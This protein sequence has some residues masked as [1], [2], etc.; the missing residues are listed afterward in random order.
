MLVTSCSTNLSGAILQQCLRDVSKKYEKS[1]G[2]FSGNVTGLY[3][4]KSASVTHKKDV[5]RI[6]SDFISP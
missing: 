3:E 4:A 6:F 2:L 1:E 5:T